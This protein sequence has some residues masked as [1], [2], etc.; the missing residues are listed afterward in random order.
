MNKVSKEK[1]ELYEVVRPLLH[2]AYS[3]VKVM[4]GKSNRNSSTSTKSRLSINC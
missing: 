4:S 1:V 2:S 3:E